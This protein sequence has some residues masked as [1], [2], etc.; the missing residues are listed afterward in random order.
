MAPQKIKPSCEKRD[1]G[2]KPILFSLKTSDTERE[3]RSAPIITITGSRAAIRMR[4]RSEATGARISITGPAKS[5][6]HVPN[7]RPAVMPP[8]AVVPSAS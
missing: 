8:D 1:F 3:T 6:G 2:A 7:S 5:Y 4:D